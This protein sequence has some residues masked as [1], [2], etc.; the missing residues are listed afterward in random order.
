[1][2]IKD[3]GYNPVRIHHESTNSQRHNDKEDAENFLVGKYQNHARLQ[4][5]SNNEWPL[6]GIKNRGLYDDYQEKQNDQ[7]YDMEPPDGCYANVRGDGAFAKSTIAG[8]GFNEVLTSNLQNVD[9]KI[10]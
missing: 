2:D 3:D 10:K 9:G 1:M 4:E 5:N 6:N 7:Q 8:D